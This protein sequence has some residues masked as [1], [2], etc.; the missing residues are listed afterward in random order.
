MCVAELQIEFSGPIVGDEV[1]LIG[2]DFASGHVAIPLEQ[3]NITRATVP[4][5]DTET[6]TETG[7]A[8]TST[9]SAAA[10]ATAAAAAA[11]EA[12]LGGLFA[13]TRAAISVARERA[14]AAALPASASVLGQA[15]SIAA[16]AAVDRGP[17]R[18]VRLHAF[19]VLAMF[20]LRLLMAR[21]V[22][23]W[24]SVPIAAPDSEASTSLRVT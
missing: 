19:C 22:A 23:F 3:L 1:L 9:A 13:R 6:E 10:V 15:A 21:F 11:A 7:T 16:A 2:E 18:A 5:N 20:E 24:Q 17:W 12:Q 14:A 4:A 8:T